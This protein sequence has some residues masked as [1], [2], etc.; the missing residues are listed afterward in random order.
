M[1]ISADGDWSLRL[2]DIGLFEEEF[3]DT[4]AETAHGSLLEVLAGL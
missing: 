4:V 2:L 3:L 1:D